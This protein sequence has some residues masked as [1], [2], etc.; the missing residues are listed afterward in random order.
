MKKGSR[1]APLLRSAQPISVR[2]D[3]SATWPRHNT[4]PEKRSLQGKIR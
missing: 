3:S 2:R 1:A 4:P